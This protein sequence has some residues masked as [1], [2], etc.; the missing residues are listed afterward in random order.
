MEGG[1][2]GNCHEALYIQTF[3]SEDM[4]LPVSPE[5]ANEAREQAKSI[6][7]RNKAIREDPAVFKDLKPS[8]NYYKAR[9]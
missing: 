3:Q 8:D 6:H 2:C 7:Q 4:V 5:F 9:S 1:I